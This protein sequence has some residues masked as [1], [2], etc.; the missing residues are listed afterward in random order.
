MVQMFTI[1]GMVILASL[2]DKE[3][4][5]TVPLHQGMTVIYRIEEALNCKDISSVN[6]QLTPAGAEVLGIAR[7]IANACGKLAEISTQM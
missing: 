6:H 5:P 7:E 3:G 1:N 4:N 2:Y